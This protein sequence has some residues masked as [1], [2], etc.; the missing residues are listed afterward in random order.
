MLEV[1]RS[2]EWE[3]KMPESERRESRVYLIAFSCKIFFCNEGF[4]SMF[5][6]RTFDSPCEDVGFKMTNSPL[7]RRTVF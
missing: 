3:S 2:G 4:L 6:F 1:I 5:C 7:V